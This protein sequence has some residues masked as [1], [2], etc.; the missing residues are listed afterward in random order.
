[1]AIA[2]LVTACGASDVA[3]PVQPI[4]PVASTAA[5]RTC[6]DWVRGSS[7]GVSW[8]PNGVDDGIESFVGEVPNSDFVAFK[9][10]GPIDAPIGKV[11]NVLIDTSKHYLWVPHFGGMRV[12]RNVSE[13]EKIIYRH[14]TTPPIISDRDFVA[15]VGIRKHEISGH[16]MIEFTSVEDPDAPVV[17]GI[18]RGVL[19]KSG[20]EMWPLDGGERTMVI[21]TIHADPKGGV[22]A[23]IVNLFQT[24][25]A[26]KNLLNI[27]RQAT[28]PDAFEHPRVKEEYRDYRPSCAGERQR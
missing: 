15:K 11:A 7:D 21:F 6:P 27:A 13:T 22:P 2:Q 25:Y 3:P 19:H 5:A 20:Y 16:L 9:G 1:M 28:K 8:E 14:V 10:A 12:V 18:V 17:D 24:G 4:A 23:W 26:R